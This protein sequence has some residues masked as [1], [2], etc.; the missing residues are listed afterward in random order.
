MSGQK[1]HNLYS[2]TRTCGR[3]LSS[4]RMN[5]DYWVLVPMVFGNL[6]MERHKLGREREP[7]AGQIR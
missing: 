4:K 2:D 1:K 3:E 7:G 6:Q 5:I